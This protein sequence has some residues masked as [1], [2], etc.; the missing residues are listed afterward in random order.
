MTNDLEGIKNYLNLDEEED[1][2]L[3]KDP[4]N[5]EYLQDMVSRYLKNFNNPLS[6]TKLGF[7]SMNLTS[8]L[9]IQYQMVENLIQKR[10]NPKVPAK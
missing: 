2:P 6:H 9:F 7:H 3:E 4:L 5:Q 10:N 8:P 1:D